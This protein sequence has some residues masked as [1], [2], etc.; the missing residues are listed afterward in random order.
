MTKT[1]RF[2]GIFAVFLHGT[3]A[4]L[5]A[6]S[7]SGTSGFNFL[8]IPVGA[9]AVALGQAFTSVPNDVQGL[10]YN[11]ASIASMAA[12]QVSFEHLS[13][14]SNITQESVVYGKAGKRESWSWG[15]SANYFRIGDIPRTQATLAPSGDGF[16]E[17]GS[18]STYD[19]ALGGTVAIPLGNNLS[20][21]STVKVLRESLADA[22]SNGTAVDF[23]A[24]YQA[25]EEHSWNLAAA[26][27]N[28]GI[29]TKFA[30]ASVKL[31]WTF[32][33]GA[34]GQPFSQWLMTADY[35]KREDTAGEFDVGAEVTPRRFFSLRLGYRYQLQRP[36]LGGL[37]DFSAGIGLRNK[38][39]SIDYA[40]VPLGDLGQTHR[41]SFNLRFKPNLGTVNLKPS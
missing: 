33:A 19:M 28:L 30:D 38:N 3:A 11:P 8:T 41:I 27:Q 35:V 23:G 32:R 25:E 14:V 16:T 2:V 15:L 18:F 24:L 36:D 10:V 5:W 29:A 31:P 6:G 17:V 7:Y 37:S 22:S 13:Y 40:F 21:G 39:M 34:S 1:L 9:R 26:I 4:S 20:V 12:S